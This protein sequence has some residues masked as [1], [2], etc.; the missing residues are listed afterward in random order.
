[1]HAGNEDLAVGSADIVV[2]GAEFAVSDALRSAPNQ[3]IVT[4][5]AFGT[6]GPWV[7]RPATE[8]TLQAA[9]GSTGGRGLPDETPLAAGGR[10]GEWLTGI[11]AA[12]GALAGW[13]RAEHAGVGTHVDVAILDC[14]AR[15]H[16]RTSPRCSPTSPPP[17]AGHRVTASSRRI[18]VPSIEPTADGW[19]NF[20]TNSAQQFADFA[21]AHRPPGDADDERYALAGARFANRDE[22]WVMT[23]AYTRPRTSGTVL[24][25]A[26]LLRI[27]VAP[28][29]DATTVRQFEQFVTRG[30][31]V[32]HPSGRFHQPRIPYRL[33]GV[34]PRPFGP[35]PEP[36]E[37]DGAIDWEPRRPPE[38]DAAG[39]L[40]LQGIRVVD[41]TAWWAGPSATT[42]WGVS[43]R[44]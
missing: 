27:P 24:E 5:S 43:A 8:F 15:R 6:Y 37:H 35:V 22:F 23:R 29:L 25:E 31:F 12:V 42:P 38:P 17:A 4:I 32:K 19:V 14:M 26:G 13:W 1:M 36:G 30:V 33:H 21:A 39:A 16:E 41:L 28:V 40:P 10:L 20:T 11:Y 9:C 7:G 2:A 34:I 3:V 44:T 18:E